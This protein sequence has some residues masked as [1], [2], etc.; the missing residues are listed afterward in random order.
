MIKLIVFLGNYGREYEKTRHNVAW[1]FLDLL[2]FEN[3]LNWQKKF[4]GQFA[5]CSPEDLARW[6]C[7]NKICSTKEG[8]PIPVLEES[9]NQLY[10]LKP[11]TYMNLSGQSIIEVTNFY[12]IKP[13][14]I[15]VIHDELEL[16]FGTVS[17]KFSGGL[18]G[19]N[20]LRSTNSVLNSPDF[21]RLRFGIGRPDKPNI[22]VADYVLGHFTKEEQEII[23]NIFAQTT[24][25]FI[26]AIFSK[27]P[28]VLIEKQGWNKKKVI[29]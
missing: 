9:P 14:E 6:A 10:F 16:Q 22:S 21:Y 18:G 28:K 1:Y 20:G 29:E 8:Q 7:E 3:K 19:H 17:L 11:E 13:E 25:L 2:P 12:K 24:L 15:L 26:K 4:K 27:D 23:P 5:I